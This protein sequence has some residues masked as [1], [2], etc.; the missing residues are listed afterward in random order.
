MTI[1]QLE[2]K[3]LVIR[4]VKPHGNGAVVYIPKT[5]IG[6]KVGIIRGIKNGD[7]I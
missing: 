6:E 4:E 1:F 7:K 5:W 2:G 3:E